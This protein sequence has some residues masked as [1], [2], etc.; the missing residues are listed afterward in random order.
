MFQENIGYSL[1]EED[2]MFREEVARIEDLEKRI[3]ALRG[4]L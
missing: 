4:S 3:I 2:R 1:P